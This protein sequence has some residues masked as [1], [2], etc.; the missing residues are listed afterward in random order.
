MSEGLRK[1]NV[2]ARGNVKCFLIVDRRI[3]AAV[4]R[5]SRPLAGCSD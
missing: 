3:V 2:E 1:T 4:L 5:P